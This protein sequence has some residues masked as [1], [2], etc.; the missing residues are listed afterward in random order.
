MQLQRNRTFAATLLHRRQRLAE[1]IDF[2]VILWSGRSS[3]RNYPANTFPFRASSHFL[4]FAGLPLENAAIRLEAGKLELFMDDASPASAL[5]HGEMPKREKIAQAIGA[6]A[7]FSMAELELRSADA[8]TI[9]VQDAATGQQQAQIMHRA[10]ASANA[11]EGIDRELARAIVL[12]R[13]SHD[14]GALA[15]LRQAA[16]V[17]VEAHL[18]GMAAIPSAKLEAGVR[19]A[20]ES[21]I[22]SHNMSC[23]YPSIVTVHG[24]VLHNQQYYHP[25]QSGGLLLADVGAETSMGWAADVTRTLPVSGK[26]SST[27]RDIYN[28]VLAAHDACIAQIR[29]DV[30]YGEI[31]L[32]AATVIAQGLVDLG[33]LRG[34]AEDLVEMDAH[35]LFF[36][37]GIGH[38]V[39]L[40]VHDME[41]LGD[42]AGYEEGRI[43]S[44]RFGLAYLRLNRPLRSGMLVTI[45]PGFYQVPAILNDPDFRA[46]YQDVVNWDRLSQFDNV[47]GIRIEDDVLVTQSGSEV[48]TAALPTDADLIESLVKRESRA[49]FGTGQPMTGKAP[50]GIPTFIKRCRAIFEQVSPQLMKDHADWFI[51]IEAD[52]GEYFL[53]VDHKVAKQKA[54]EKYPDGLISTLQ[55]V[56]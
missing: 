42:L 47:R 27:Q 40:D 5:W 55:L 51:A 11:S 52:S 53:D 37:H 7:A 50:A 8:A 39:G 16:S 3:S 31:H 1:L 18:A 54:L 45:E 25:L 9:S 6:D 10:I 28:L 15:E 21:V 41:D 36:P 13:L 12:L 19:A 34:S 24:E 32:L 20:M 48:L 23:A 43:R 38:L 17:T 14:A 46:K 29:P 2:P 33:I 56:E 49:F 4:Y 22:I 26:F 44:D 30:E 35:A